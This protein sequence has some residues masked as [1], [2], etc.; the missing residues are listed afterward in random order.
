MLQNI[1]CPLD[2]SHLDDI[3]DLLKKHEYS[4]D[5]YYVLG[6]HLGLHHNTLNVIEATNKGDVWSY[7]RECLIKWLKRVDDVKS[8]GGPSYE[9]LIR[10]LR[11]M[12][13]NAVADGIERDINSKD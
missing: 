11:R 5:D 10:A 2:V 3:L 7:L 6:L 9:S 8:K 1:F 13:E 4:G 12:G